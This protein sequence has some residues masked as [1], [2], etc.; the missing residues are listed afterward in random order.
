MVEEGELKVDKVKGEENPADLIPNYLTKGVSDA[1]R[2]RLRQEVV[3]GR[4]EM[5]LKL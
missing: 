2:V 4:A 1:R 3:Q 5:S